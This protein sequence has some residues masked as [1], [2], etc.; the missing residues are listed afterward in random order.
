MPFS[1]KARWHASRH[2]SLVMR[3]ALYQPATHP[4]NDCTLSVP[5]GVARTLDSSRG[6]DPLCLA[7]FST[8]RDGE[9]ASA[10][11]GSPKLMQAVTA[12]AHAITLKKRTIHLHGDRTRTSEVLSN[13]RVPRIDIRRFPNCDWSP[14]QGLANRTTAPSYGLDRRHAQATAKAFEPRNRGVHLSALRGL[15]WGIL[16]ILIPLQALILAG[17]LPS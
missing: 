11:L 9:A 16:W 12:A 5:F 2:S 13:N 6:W 3:A 7:G 15:D 4:V 14:A 17:G 8:A 10:L 1:T